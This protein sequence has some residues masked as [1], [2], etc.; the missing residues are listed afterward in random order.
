MIGKC[1]CGQVQFKLKGKTPNLYQCHCKLCR[2]QGGSASNTATIVDLTSFSWI[3]SEDKITYYKKDSG[4]SSNF[5]SSCGSPV[6]N[7]LRD[8]D[9]QW[10]PAGLLDGD[11]KLLIVA[12]IYTDSKADWAEIPVSGMHYKTMPDLEEF[13]EVLQSGTD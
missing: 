13:L 10:I 3:S 8:S 5:C 7:K 4:F 6:P 2:K 11:D 12:H 1:I 9:Y